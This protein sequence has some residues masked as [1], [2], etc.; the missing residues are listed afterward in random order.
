MAT[1][2][3]PLLGL[4]ERPEKIRA[5]LSPSNKKILIRDPASATNS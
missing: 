3:P 2:G 5:S 1:T 4:R